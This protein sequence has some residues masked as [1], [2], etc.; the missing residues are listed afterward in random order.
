MELVRAGYDREALLEA[1]FAP[2][3]L[4][5]VGLKE[6]APEVLT[7]VGLKEADKEQTDRE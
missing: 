3:V 5:A 7:A 2:A 4:T 1:G 6:V